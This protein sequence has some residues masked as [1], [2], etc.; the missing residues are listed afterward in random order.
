VCFVFQ[1]TGTKDIENKTTLLHYLVETIETNFPELLS[2]GEELSHVDRAARVAVDN[3][4][5]ALRQMDASV[6][7]LETDLNNSRVPQGED[8]R[9]AQVMGVSFLSSR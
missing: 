8:D 9:F 3:V 6:R 2:F 4:Q 1:L 5:K 7:N